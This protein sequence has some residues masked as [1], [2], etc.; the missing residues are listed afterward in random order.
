MLS[1]CVPVIRNF[2]SVALGLI[3]A[4]ANS[5]SDGDG[6]GVGVSTACVDLHASGELII[7][8]NCDIRG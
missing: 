5:R 4:A 6:I 1:H 8:V 7:D 2:A 3:S